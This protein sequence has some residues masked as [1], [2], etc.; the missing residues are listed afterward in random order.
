[1]LEY[2]FCADNN[3]S[4]DVFSAI[5]LNRKALSHNRL[6]V[7]FVKISFC[8]L[9]SFVA[10]LYRNILFFNVLSNIRASAD[11]S[12]SSMSCLLE[13]N[14]SDSNCF[15]ILLIFWLICS[16]LFES[17]LY[18]RIHCSL[19]EM[20]SLSFCIAFVSFLR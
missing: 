19:F 18:V 7:S 20:V 13:M 15:L 17:S 9:F 16:S 3:S 2:V 10:L 4:I 11:L 6:P 1:M 12:H 14:S 5:C 8:I